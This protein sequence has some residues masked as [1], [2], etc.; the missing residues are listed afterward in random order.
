[1]EGDFDGYHSGYVTKGMF[2]AWA[3]LILNGDHLSH[4]ECDPSMLAYELR[5]ASQ[6]QPEHREDYRKETP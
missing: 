3:D 4:V 5:T 1:M 2:F 6:R